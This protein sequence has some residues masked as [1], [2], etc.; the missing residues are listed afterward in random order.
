MPP[1]FNLSQDQTLQFD[2]VKFILFRV[3]THK[4]IE[5]NF[6]SPWAFVVQALVPKNL[7]IH[8]QTPTLIGCIFLMFHKSN[9]RSYFQTP[10]R[11]AKPWI[12]TGLFISCQHQGSLQPPTSPPNLITTSAAIP[13]SE[14]SYSTPLFSN[15]STKLRN[16]F[17]SPSTPPSA[18]P[19]CAETAN[20]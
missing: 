14:A 8:I 18:T 1:A 19:A 6:T 5:V 11:S 3:F 13:S 2:L 16:F 15:I 4:E 10:L 20:H 12:I 17:Q 7:A 9:F